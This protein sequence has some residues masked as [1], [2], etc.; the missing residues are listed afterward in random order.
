LRYL[1]LVWA[2]ILRKPMRAVL[3]LLAVTVAFTVFGLMIGLSATIHGVEDRARDDRI[4]SS[5]RFGYV[6]GLPIAVA[7]QI[8]AIPGVKGITVSS[9]I[10]GYVQEPKNRAYVIMADA[11]MVKVFPDWFISQAMWDMIQ[12]QRDGIVMS[13]LQAQRW[14][15]KVGDTF[16][17]ISPSTTKADGTTT[18]TFKV[19]AISED[20]PI[21]T[22]GVIFG[23]YGY[24]DKSLP[25]ADQGKIN[26]IDL[27]ATDPAQTAAI[28]QDIDDKFANSATP[29]RTDTEK[30]AYAVS[31]GFGGMDIDTL[32]HEIALAGLLMILF[33]TANVIAQSV[34]ERF[35]EFATL[36]A[37]GYGDHVVIG[38]VVLEA[39]VPCVAGAGLGVGLAAFLA[40]H[41]QAIVPPGFGIP[42]PAMSA[43]VFGGAGISALVLAFVSAVLPAIRLM[44]MDIATALSGRT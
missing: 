30:A 44:R 39:F 4:F 43:T 21:A 12:H 34:R 1:P 28:A 42:T 3:T 23:N 29:T 40:G 26:E 24:Y 7:H 2:A 5:A 13:R 33:L 15:K 11:D 10:A 19:L 20:N 27:N 9:V 18:W 41:I 8:A 35:A 37:M 38:L 32:T 17:L 31:N 25:L 22:D 16:T 14:H 36:R 6:G